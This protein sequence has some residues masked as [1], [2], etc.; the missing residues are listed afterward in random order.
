[1]LWP[2]HPVALIGLFS[3]FLVV[4][5]P[6]SSEP[7]L[8]TK[9]KGIYKEWIED[10]QSRYPPNADQF[11]RG[12][13][14]SHMRVTH[15][16]MEAQ[17]LVYAQSEYK[18]PFVFHHRSGQPVSYALTRVPGDEEPGTRWNLRQN[19]EIPLDGIFF[20]RFDQTGPKLLRFEAV[21]AGAHTPEAM[22][23]QALIGR[24]GFHLL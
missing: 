12:N 11:K 7:K 22:S 13:S 23:M 16:N 9:E 6:P 20:W 5:A 4:V 15:P 18:G 8:S 17:A 14:L 10:Y 1:M 3:L 2:L 24:Y 21:T 19:G